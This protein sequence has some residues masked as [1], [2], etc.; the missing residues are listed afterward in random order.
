MQYTVSAA[1]IANKTPLA[2]EVKATGSAI[3]GVETAATTLQ[4][5]A[6]TVEP[7]SAPGPD[8]GGL[9]DTGGPGYMLL[10]AMGLLLLAGGAV[11]GASGLLRRL[12]RDMARS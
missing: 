9:A 1:D 11:L 5:V 3:T 2:L 7:E 8:G 10:T 6:V 12:R 4:N